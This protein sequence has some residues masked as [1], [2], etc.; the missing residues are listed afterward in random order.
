MTIHDLFMLL[1][2][3]ETELHKVETRRNRERLDLLLHPK[4]M[5]FARSGRQYS[6][7]EVLAEFSSDE[8]FE[9][10]HAQDFVLTELG[11][12]IALLTY[13]SAHIDAAGN[14]YRWTLRSSLWVQTSKGWQMRF[15]QG[16]PAEPLETPNL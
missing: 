5:E 16:T 11:V 14:L 6:R 8:E 13:R 1:R 7:A 4:F 12:G 15:H 2:Q 3:S 9:L 10:V